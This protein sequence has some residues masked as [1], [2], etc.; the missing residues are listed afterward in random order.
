[1]HIAV[2]GELGSGCTEVG[3]IISK[4]LGLKS[5]SSSNLVRLIVTDFRGV[6]PDESFGEFEQ[7]VRSGEVN[8]DKMLGSKLDE[9]LEQGDVV[10]EGRSAFMLLN[11]TG[12]FKILLTAPPNIRIEHIA[13]RRSITT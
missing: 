7:H 4:R 6:H 1:M 9:I 2:C 13:K 5:I 3:Q 11:K 8:L 10:V 12:V